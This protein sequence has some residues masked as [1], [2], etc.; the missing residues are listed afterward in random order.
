MFLFKANVLRACTVSSSNAKP[1]SEEMPL[2]AFDQVSDQGC[3]PF[4]W[5]LVFP[6]ITNPC[7]INRAQGNSVCSSMTFEDADPQGVYNCWYLR[8]TE[9]FVFMVS[10]LFG[11]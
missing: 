2:G 11:E 3:D 1:E 10:A 9:S 8:T 5:N 6:M 7:W 4:G